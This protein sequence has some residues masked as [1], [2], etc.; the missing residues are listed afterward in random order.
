MSTHKTHYAMSEDPGKKGTLNILRK[1][2][3]LSGGDYIRAETLFE[4]TWYSRSV[5]PKKKKMDPRKWAIKIFW[6]EYPRIPRTKTLLESN[7]FGFALE[8]RIL[9]IFSCILGGLKRDGGWISNGLTRASTTRIILKFL[10]GKMKKIR[11]F[12]S[13]RAI[14]YY[15]K[16]AGKFKNNYK[17][18][19]KLNERGVNYRAL[20]H[21]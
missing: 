14:Y 20:G 4:K 10:E 17:W 8:D 1:C 6:T 9:C 18:S 5:K 19:T 21:Y 12:R 16:W 2:L 11:K 13:K 7:L 3:R 15:E